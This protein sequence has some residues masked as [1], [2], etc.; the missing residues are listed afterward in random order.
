M[1]DAL[2]LGA[3]I[4]CASSAS[5]LLI[6]LSSYFGRR[7]SAGRSERSLLRGPGLGI[8]SLLA[9]GLAGHAV[10]GLWPNWPAAGA[11]DRFLLVGL[12]AAVC[13]E[14]VLARLDLR[15]TLRF[16]LGSVG[17]LLLCRLL[18]SGSVYTQNSLWEQTAILGGSAAMLV[19]VHE[20]SRGLGARAEFASLTLT[21]AAVLACSGALIM[22]AGYLKG[23]AAALLWSAAAA[24]T[25]LGVIGMKSRVDLRGVVGLEIVILFALVFIG[26][27]FG[28]LPAASA[29][30]LFL[31]PIS[32][33]GIEH[34]AFAS[35]TVWQKQLLRLAVVFALVLVVLISGK[36]KFDREMRPLLGTHRTLG[37]GATVSG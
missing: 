14:L 4:L 23:G 30:L 36:R 10:L 34:R 35:R 27:F 9:G 28:R 13:V 26:L 5:A 15:T 12:P 19:L 32:G 33:W 16:L 1:T 8:G 31:A 17:A 25:A 2:G 7:R 3:A 29:V 37:A 20:L 18:L 21:I 22:M 24:G 11:L 6:V